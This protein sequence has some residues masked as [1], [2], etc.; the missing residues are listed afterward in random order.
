MTMGLSAALAG[1]HAGAKTPAAKATAA[2]TLKTEG[3][4]GTEL[5]SGG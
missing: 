2:R 1:P 3:A 5:N 4:E